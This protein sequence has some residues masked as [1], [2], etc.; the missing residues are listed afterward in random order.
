MN[1]LNPHAGSF[2]KLVTVEAD[3]SIP[4]VELDR[5]PCLIVLVPPDSDSS[6]YTRRIC[7]LATETNS[8]IQLLGVCTDASQELAL[9]RDLI[10]VAALIRDVK[11]YVETS[12]EVGTDWVAA[13]KRS[14]HQGD[15]IV[16][17]ADQSVGFRRRPLSQLLE[18]TFKAPI[19]IL[20]DTKVHPLESSAL[21][22]VISW[23]GFV[24]IIIGFFF[25]QVKITQLPD[26]WFQTL[27]SIL[28]IIPE[29]GLIL[30]WNSL[31]S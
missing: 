8:N 12:V 10:T 14:Y 7:R 5:S 6:S 15:M 27:L 25:L 18:S 11:V 29:L 9:R 3:T 21:S 28:T 24:G 2:T 4:A 13:V 20:S 22:Q 1:K 23:V 19:Y 17:I 31:F 26:D 30:L 16:C